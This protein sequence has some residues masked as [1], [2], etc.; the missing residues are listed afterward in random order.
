[1][2]K[3]LKVVEFATW[4]AA[5]SAAAVMADWGA[6]V[7]KIESATGDPTRQLFAERPELKGNPVFEFENRGKRGAVIDIRKPKGREALLRI[8]ADTDIFLTNLRPGSLK[9]AKLDFDSIHGRLPKL[10]YC[11][12]SGYGLTGEGIDLPAFDIAALWTRSGMARACIPEEIEPFSCRPGM[13]DSI[14]ALASVAAVLAAL[15]ERGRTGVGRLVETSLL[16][17]GIYTMGWDMSVQLK[18]GEL[19]TTKPRKKPVNPISN[20]YRTSDGKW[21]SV[22]SRAPTDWPKIAAAAGRQDMADNARFATHQDRVQHSEEI[23]AALD[24]GFGALT[25]AEVAA[26]LTANDIIWAPLQSPADVTQ[27]PYAHAAGCF[28]PVKDAD[29]D[30]FLAPASPARF[31]GAKDSPTQPAPRLGEH[32]RAILSEVGY[33]PDEIE[34][35]IAA[36]DIA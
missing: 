17:T 25:L 32:T 34:K 22:S 1:M 3:G 35:M 12:V 21:F 8:L 26:R 13:G 23:V 27:D 30:E 24:A 11:S 5:P 4:V 31:H 18:F 10:I 6:E 33:S 29:G 19:T 7:I 16:R 15:A 36:G 20:Y 2:L 28:V 9:R 14:C